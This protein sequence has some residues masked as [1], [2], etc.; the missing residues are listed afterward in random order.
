VV[1]LL[2]ELVVGSLLWA[3]IIAGLISVVRDCM[4]DRHLEPTV[5]NHEEEDCQHCCGLGSL[6]ILPRQRE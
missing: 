6:E 1:N 3:A 2:G 5:L 4:K